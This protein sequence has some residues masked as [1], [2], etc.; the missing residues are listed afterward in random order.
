MDFHNYSQIYNSF[1]SVAVTFFTTLIIWI[2]Y[3]RRNNKSSSYKG[4][5]A[6]IE[7]FKVNIYDD[8]IQGFKSL[9]VDYKGKP[10]DQNLVYA[11]GY[12][13]NIGNIDI[14]SDITDSPVELVAFINNSWEEIKINQNLTSAN[15]SINNPNAIIDFALLKQN[16]ALEIDILLNSNSK[17]VIVIGDIKHRIKDVEPGFTRIIYNQDNIQEVKSTYNAYLWAQGILQVLVIFF[18]SVYAFSN[19]PS[20]LT[21]SRSTSSQQYRTS[22]REVLEGNKVS[23]IELNSGEPVKITTDSLNNRSVFTPR[24]SKTIK[25]LNFFWFYYLESLLLP[26]TIITL[27]NYF[28]KFKLAK[29]ISSIVES[30][31]EVKTQ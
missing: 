12:L 31:R 14:T 9:S 25:K 27:I 5:I 18:L 3:N 11:K 1:T 24:I 22:G 26:M 8:F 6:F 23:L 16:E 19:N 13:A 30:K 29:K 21:V 17:P 15:V 28:K 10:V 4:K 7:M 2:L 20:I